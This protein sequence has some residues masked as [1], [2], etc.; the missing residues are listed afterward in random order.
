MEPGGAFSQRVQ[1]VHSIYV[2]DENALCLQMVLY[3]REY[4]LPVIKM[5][6]MIDGIVDAEDDVEP[7]RD[8]KVSHVLP[9]E[10]SLRQALFGD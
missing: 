1:L 10:R 4:L 7:S 6:K 5:G 3:S 8:C 9:E 2:E